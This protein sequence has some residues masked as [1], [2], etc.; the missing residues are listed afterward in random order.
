MAVCDAVSCKKPFQS[1]TSRK[2]VSHFRL[3]SQRRLFPILAADLS[4]FR[5]GPGSHDVGCLRDASLWIDLGVTLVPKASSRRAFLSK[6]VRAQFRATTRSV[7]QMPYVY[8]VN[9]RCNQVDGRQ[10]NGAAWASGTFRAPQQL[11]WQCVTDL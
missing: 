6:V 2:I 11:R 7:L 8:I 9:K 10:F 5:D 1:A 4:T 3:E